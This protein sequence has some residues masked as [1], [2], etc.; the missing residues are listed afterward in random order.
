[1][2]PLLTRLSQCEY[3]NHALGGGTLVCKDVGEWADNTQLAT[4]ET[5]NLIRPDIVVFRKPRDGSNPPWVDPDFAPGGDSARHV[6]AARNSFAHSMIGVEPK[7]DN[8]A[9]GDKGS[10]D[11]LLDTAGAKKTRGQICE[12][13]N[14]IFL[15]Q[16]RQFVFFVH[17]Y[18]TTARL[19]RFDRVGVVVSKP[20]DLKTES[21]QLYKFFFRLR[22]ASDTQLGLD[23]TATMVPDDPKCQDIID[24]KAALESLPALDRSD[25]D[26]RAPSIRKAFSG[27]WPLYKLR[28]PDPSASKPDGAQFFLVRNPCTD[29]LSLTG[30][31]T[32]G[33][34]AFDLQTKKWCFVKDYWRADSK[35]IHSEPEVY[36]KL[37]KAKIKGIATFLCGSDLRVS[38]QNTGPVQCTRTQEHM[39]GKGKYYRRIHTRLALKEVGIPLSEYKTS[40][41]LCWII[42][43]AFSGEFTHILQLVCRQLI[44]FSS[45]RGSLGSGCLTP[46]HQ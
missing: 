35:D 6:H 9:F 45:A 22:N 12:Y 26:R 1:M 11:F 41:E 3:I 18:R 5:K 37:Q 32:K 17:I 2:A 25:L 29:P 27:G 7:L 44:V 30:R 28:I 39:S 38:C 14:H 10:G 42:L 24:L 36:A 40:Y 15:R 13:V 19:M 43:W 4:G 31:A 34:I 16:H 33:Y 8:P 23:P 20:I 21:H 46:R